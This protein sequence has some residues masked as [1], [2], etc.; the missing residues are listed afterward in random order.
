MS[1]PTSVSSRLHWLLLGV[2][3]FTLVAGCASQRY[4]DAVIPPMEETEAM[5]AFIGEDL[6]LNEEQLRKLRGIVTENAKIKR[7]IRMQYRSRPLEVRE[8]TDARI[9]KFERKLGAILTPEQRKLFGAL[10][11]AIQRSELEDLPDANG[12]NM[13]APSDPTF[14]PT[15]GY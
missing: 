12:A 2:L 10:M 7:N 4:R 14:D 9:D 1:F 15:R 13:R 6:Q 8:A 3:L 11:R 5:L